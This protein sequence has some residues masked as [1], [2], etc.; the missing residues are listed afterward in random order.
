MTCDQA[1]SLTAAQVEERFIAAVLK[2]DAGERLADT[3]RLSPDAFTDAACRRA[4]RALTSAAS[5][6]AG[7]VHSDVRGFF[8]HETL[9]ADYAA[10]R[11]AVYIA[12]LSRLGLAGVDHWRAA[13]PS[14]GKEKV[15]T[16]MAS[17]RFNLETQ[18]SQPEPRFWITGKPVCTPG[19][20]TNLIAQAKAGK[21]AFLASMIAAAICAER[22]AAERDT[23]GISAAAPGKRVLV[24][25]DT[26]QSPYDHDQ[27]V[28]RALRRAGSDTSPQ[29]LWSYALAG[30]SADELKT[31]LRLVLT[32]ATEAGGVFAVIIDGTADLVTDVNDPG[33]C[34]PFVA[35][36]HELAI[37][38]ACPIINVV[39]ENPGQDSGKMRGH[40][41]SQLE[42]KAESNLRLR[43][44][45]GVTVVFSER[46]R[47]API[48]E[49]DG[50]R[51][52]WSDDEG[53]HVSCECARSTRAD[54]LREIAEEVI[55]T[56][57]LRYTEL[58]SG[59]VTARGG[60]K[61]TAE[62]RFSEMK[63][64]GVIIQQPIGRWSIV[65]DV[66]KAA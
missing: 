21:T 5:Y 26:E 63:K 54:E 14:T 52:Q 8:A 64:A 61:K 33:E 27:L 2:D 37:R 34:N 48:L 47:G 30:F 28:R 45:E 23:L 17:R 25:F 51:F 56:A 60:S 53:M 22:G 66:R 18:P 16:R 44:E 29:W 62:R 58:V 46:M 43:K 15:R 11:D 41:G 39:H 32:D 9:G 38:Y 59:I 19:N 7:A 50:P 35:E 65:N 10:D 57:S 6:E 1:P 3:R 20:L 55:G 13:L 42:R 4:W 40:L 36:L 31:A 24:H 49:A 12:W